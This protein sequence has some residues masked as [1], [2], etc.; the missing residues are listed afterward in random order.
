[1]RKD[2]T[3]FRKRFQ[4]WK[5]GIPA[6]E[7]GKPIDY[8][9][10]AQESRDREYNTAMS[11]FKSTPNIQNLAKGIYHFAKS[12]PLLGDTPA[13]VNPHTTYGDVPG[14][15]FRDPKTLLET[16]RRIREAVKP[17]V[18]GVS[19][20]KL[21]T[22]ALQQEIRYGDTYYPEQLTI[23][24]RNALP[25][26][27]QAKLAKE[28]G[29]YVMVDNAPKVGQKNYILMENG[30]P[31]AEMIASME[32]GDI[33]P[34]MVYKTNKA[35]HHTTTDLYSGVL[36]YQKQAGNVTK[37]GK[38][39]G[40]RSSE[41]RMSDP[42][43]DPQIRQFNRETI[44]N[45]GTWSN[46][47]LVGYD[48]EPTV[49]KTR[50]EAENLHKKG[51]AYVLY[52]Q[53]VYRL[54][55]PVKDIPI[56]DRYMFDP[57]RIGPN[58]E[59]NVD[60]SNP[61]RFAQNQDD[62]NQ[63]HYFRRGK[64]LPR[65]ADGVD[66]GA[67]P[68]NATINSDGTFTDDYTKI[69]NDFIITPNGSTT[70]YGSYT[71]K[72]WD[73]YQQYSNWLKYHNQTTGKLIGEPGLELVSPEFDLLSG[74]RGIINVAPVKPLTYNKAKNLSDEQWDLL[75][76]NAIKNGN[77]SEIQNIRDLHFKIKS[78]QNT[79]VDADGNPIKTY[80]TVSD[81]Y[82]PSF[83][84]FN[85]N[86]EGDLSNIYTTD[87]K[88]M[89]GTYSSHL[90]DK[91]ELD[92]II[93]STRQMELNHYKNYYNLKDFQKKQIAI[94]QD[95]KKARKQIL[96]DHKWLNGTFDP[97]RQKQLYVYLKNPVTM[98]AGNR[99]WAHL[100]LNELPEDVFKNIRV[101]PRGGIRDWYSTRSLENAIKD[102]DYDGAIVKDVLDYGGAKRYFGPEII[103]YPG[104]VFSVKDPKFIKYADPITYDDFGNIIPISKRDNFNVSD[105]RYSIFPAIAAGY[106][107]SQYK[108][109]KDIYIKPSH[110]GRFTAL[111]KRTGHSA[112]WFKAHGTPAQKKMATFELNSKKWHKH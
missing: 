37:E 105:L 5:Q 16:T 27:R 54:L 100:P 9:K 63:R 20:T 66:L 32:N 19:N 77:K 73:R 72:N 46:E 74:I 21:S 104:T 68:T 39:A 51:K 89:S 33:I 82:D 65:F 110:R 43:Q 79:A 12:T 15:G 97:N 47:G 109:G 71:D 30:R 99:D 107:M 88:F 26:L 106:G 64:D 40:I 95:P 91:E 92:H 96:K 94:L 22:Q 38:R 28:K 3:E 59:Y 60:M 48:K 4:S 8:T 50:K 2:P 76:N 18:K 83:N 61:S 44:S 6:Y 112:S 55:Q 36:K 13:S 86:I 53:P 29:K 42:A 101:D 111:K 85:Q 70:P 11:Y 34:E 75:Y 49:V 108:S 93:E 35:A 98:N 1:M 23:A 87:N 31:Q 24:E 81:E 14:A 102:L 58:G 10:V 25:R 56:K 67:N 17:L 84:A 57:R 52:N 80:H 45:E 103:N 69:F 62:S 78:P 41:N 7:D 90:L